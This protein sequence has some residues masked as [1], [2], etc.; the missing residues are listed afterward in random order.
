MIDT[1]VMIITGTRKGIGKYLA[2]YY[3]E[4]GFI[5]IGCSRGDIDFTLNNYKHYSLDVS[6][7]N[8]VKIMFKEIRKE[9]GRLDILINN[10]GVNYALSPILL[11]PFESALKTVKINLLGTFLFTRESVKIMKINSF[12]RIINFGSMAMKHEVKGEAIYAASKAAIVSMTRVIAKEIY[13][14][15]ITCNVISPSAIET[16][17]MKNINRDSLKKLLG[18]NAI[19]DVGNLKDISN[20]I[21]YLIKSESHA[22]TGQTV[23]LGGV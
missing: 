4:K 6:D 8:L 23:W 19:P 17:L 16:D 1:P 11:V 20:I 2:E 12:G 22:I 14:F 7:E 9:Y 21:N 3:I 15:G 18:Q 5:V 13:G 10:A